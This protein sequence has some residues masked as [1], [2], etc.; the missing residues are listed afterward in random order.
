MDA[1]CALFST[2]LSLE[3]QPATSIKTSHATR[4]G[5]KRHGGKGDAKGSESEI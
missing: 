4:A 3:L 1:G 5:R 2:S